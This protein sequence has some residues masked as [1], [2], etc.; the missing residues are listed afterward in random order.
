MD[1]SFAFT[2]IQAQLATDVFVFY[3]HCFKR[4]WRDAQ[5]AIIFEVLSWLREFGSL[6]D[7]GK[8]TN[9]QAKKLLTS[10]RVTFAWMKNSTLYGA[11]LS[12]TRTIN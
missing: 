4:A 3:Q 2:V 12:E 1:D 5:L 6:S 11:M 8:G 10:L 7:R 9:R